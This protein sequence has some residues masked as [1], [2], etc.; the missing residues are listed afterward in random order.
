MENKLAQ[1]RKLGYDGCATFVSPGRKECMNQKNVRT[2]KY[3]G[4]DG[5]ALSG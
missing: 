4:G 3:M 1:C 5:E 2:K